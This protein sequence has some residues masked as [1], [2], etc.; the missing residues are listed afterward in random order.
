MRRKTLLPL[1]LSLALLL[2]GCGGTGQT[3]S[4][5][6]T[7]AQ[8]DPEAELRAELQA[9]F[10]AFLDEVNET[11]Q[12]RCAG[13]PPELEEDWT[14]ALDSLAGEFSPE[15]IDALL[16][17]PRTT[18]VVSAQEAMEDVETC[19]RLLRCSYGAYDYFGGD[20]VFGPIQQDILDELAG[21]G[22]LNNGQLAQ[23]M[24]EHLSPV[25]VDGHFKIGGIRMADYHN[26]YM[27]YV[28][29]VWFDDDTGLDLALVK[30]TV[31]GTGRLRKCLAVL[32][33]EAEAEA[34]PETLE[35]DG[36][37]VALDWKKDE[38]LEWDGGDVFNEETLADGTPWLT[39]GAMWASDEEG[40]AQLDRLAGC[41]GAYA[42]APVLVLDVRGNG[43]GSDEYINQWFAGYT[44]AK[45]QERQSFA[46]KCSDV[47][48][49]VWRRWGMELTGVG[50][51]VNGWSGQW[52]EHGGVTLVLQ[53]KG[54]ASSGETA[55][56]EVHTLEN[57]LFLGSN[58][59]GCSLTPNNED[60]YLPNTGLNLYFGT[61][62]TL[63]ED[64]EN[65]DGRGFLPDLWVP[66]GEAEQRAEAMIECYDLTHFGQN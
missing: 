29:G 56:R 46:W 12:S 52:V 17:P 42:A 38:G 18:T 25:L 9:E 39:S 19:F 45:S 13:E 20:E 24:A 47:N 10:A 51:I 27:Y 23:I 58:T 1:L 57:A 2:G 54:T 43:G 6:Q 26:R 11:H 65:L 14:P 37:P 61:C 40:Q 8:L 33:T 53:D 62:L 7:S 35:I 36:I 55:V 22:S 48:L 34:L 49:E 31:D 63:M 15:E 16:T 50:W 60:F 4:G 41:G 28:P 59:L 21:G 66:S 3:P 32:A 64:G 30:D 5:S 44:G